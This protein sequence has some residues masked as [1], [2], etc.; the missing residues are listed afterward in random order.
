LQKDLLQTLGDS[1]CIYNSP[2]EGGSFF[3]GL[4]MV[5]PVKDHDRLAKSNDELVKRVRDATAVGPNRQPRFG[6][7][8]VAFA[9][10]RI[11]CLKYLGDGMPLVLSWCITDKYLILALSPQNIRAFLSRDPAAQTL[12]DLPAV[13]QKLKAASPVLLTYQDTRELLKSGYPFLQLFAATECAQMQRD[14]IDLDASLLPSLPS[15]TRH[16]EAGLGELSRERDGLVYVSRQ[17]MPVDMT[18]SGLLPVWNSLFVF[19]SE[20]PATQPSMFGNQ[21]QIFSFSLGLAR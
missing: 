1:C 16:A 21:S 11:V 4:T 19:S 20:E 3:T 9:K 17:S 8:D 18:L 5:V 10:H 13:A 7:T 14:G 6:L 15:L 12:A 2:G